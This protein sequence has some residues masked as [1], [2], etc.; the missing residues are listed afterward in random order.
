MALALIP[1]LVTLLYG[2][3]G[4]DSCLGDDPAQHARIWKVLNVAEGRS[5]EFLHVRFF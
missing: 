3:V 1:Q 2:E 4:Q 5:G